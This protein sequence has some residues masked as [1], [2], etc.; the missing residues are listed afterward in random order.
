MVLLLME[1]QQYSYLLGQMLYSVWLVP[2]GYLAVGQ[3]PVV[4]VPASASATPAA[5]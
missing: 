5:G 1:T 3:V 2:L 4:P